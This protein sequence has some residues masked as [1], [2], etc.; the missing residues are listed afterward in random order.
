MDERY[1]Q[2]TKALTELQE[3]VRTIAARLE[4]IQRLIPPS[5]LSS[6]KTPSPAE[7]TPETLVSEKDQVRLEN[8][9]YYGKK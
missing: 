6:E 1:Q 8:V 3:N 9:F 7:K 4:A 2:L 5:P